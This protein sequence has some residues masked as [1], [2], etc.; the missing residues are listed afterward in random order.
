MIFLSKTYMKQFE[1]V[2][3]SYFLSKNRYAF[4]VELQIQCHVH[5]CLIG[6]GKLQIACH[7]GYM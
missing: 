4:Y 3:F 5:H 7:F 6:L 2:Q 1:A